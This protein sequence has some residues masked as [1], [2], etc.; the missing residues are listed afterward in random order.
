M[1]GGKLNKSQ[2]KYYNTACLM[3]EALLRLLE[4]KNYEFITVKE[5]CE[6]A[7]VNRSTFYLHYETMEDLLAECVEYTGKKISDKFTAEGYLVK[8]HIATCTPQEL[9]LITPKYL[10]P[11]LQVVKENKRV[12]MAY[13][14]QPTALRTQEISK[15]LYDDI[16]QPILQRFGVPE[17]QREYM[18]SFYLNGIWAVIS[19]WIKGGCAD[20]VADI[21]NILVRCINA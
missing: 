12:F 16:F 9:M 5:I 21:S 14:S 1:Q 10:I 19:R 17:G 18:V 15:R 20:D 8:E 6:K 4:K 7:G 13:A 3:D 11:Y 2:S